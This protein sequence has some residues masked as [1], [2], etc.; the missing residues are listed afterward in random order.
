MGI[1]RLSNRAVRVVPVSTDF[2][3]QE[4]RKKEVFVRALLPH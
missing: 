3:N 4:A 1:Y 2:L